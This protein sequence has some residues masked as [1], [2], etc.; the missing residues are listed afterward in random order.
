M[1]ACVINLPALLTF[2]LYDTSGGNLNHPHL[3]DEET[4]AQNSEI[5]HTTKKCQFQ[6]LVLGL[7]DF[8]KTHSLSLYLIT[9]LPKRSLL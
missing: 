1:S 4:S 9:S 2:Y 3:S 6:D 8:K 5:G 7:Y